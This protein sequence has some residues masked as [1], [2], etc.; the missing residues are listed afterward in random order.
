MMIKQRVNLY[1]PSLFVQRQ[2]LTLARLMLAWLAL[3]AVV[4]A[5][6]LVLQQQ[7]QQQSA[8]VADRQQQLQTMQ[9]ELSLYQQALTQRQPSPALQKQHQLLQHS[10]LQKQNLLSYL[11]G[12]QQQSS[13]FYSPVLQHL[14]QIN[15]SELWLT[16]FSLQQQHSSFAGIALKPEAVPQWLADLRRLEYFRGQRFSQISMQQVADKPAVSF[17]LTAQ[18]GAQ[19]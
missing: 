19:P 1:Q 6:L 3:I 12:Q 16:A 4:I 8:I 15:R 2:R 11:S 7:Q 9:Q 5:V 14:Q 13:L 17:S 10:V 18:Q